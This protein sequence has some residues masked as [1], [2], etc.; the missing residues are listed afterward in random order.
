MISVNEEVLLDTREDLKMFTE[1]MMGE[2]YNQQTRT[3]CECV[4]TFLEELFDINVQVKQLIQETIHK[5]LNPLFKIEIAE[6]ADLSKIEVLAFSKDENYEPSAQDSL[7]F[8]NI[9]EKY[10]KDF[11][12]LYERLFN[13]EL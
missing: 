4:I 6:T 11:E 9:C 3:V 13:L 2:T 1:L 12:P 10:L 5:D 8:D 7:N